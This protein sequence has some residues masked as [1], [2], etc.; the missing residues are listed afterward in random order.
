[1]EI[2]CLFKDFGIK[3]VR[4]R[5]SSSARSFAFL[6]VAS[7]EAV[8]LAIQN[9]N[10]TIVKGQRMIVAISEERK[11][12]ESRKDMEMPELEPVPNGL[13]IG[14]G[15]LVPTPSVQT[16]PPPTKKNLYA[17]P[18]EMRCSFLVLML[19]DCFKDLG[20]LI[21]ISRISGE[22]ALLVTDTMPQTPFFWAIHLTEENHRNMQKLFGALAEVESQMPFL[23]KQEVQQGTRCMAECILGEEGGAWNRCWV[24]DRV[25][26]LAVVFFMD[27]GRSA[28]VPL[29]AL[30]RLDKDDFWTIQPLA[31][32]FML[33][34]DFFPPQNMARQI[35]EGRVV[36]Q[37]QMESH[38]LKFITKTN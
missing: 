31:Q 5:Q 13:P 36:Q 9:R 29:N 6:E 2:A 23:S 38:I 28:T 26:D 27:F 11:S 35:L 17:V 8:Q 7:P 33:H 3:T 32:P 22:A 19:R 30:R 20:W 37:S 24:L 12:P 21:P 4:K 15:D 1:M 14:N 25:G 10:G 34:E 18:V 16:A